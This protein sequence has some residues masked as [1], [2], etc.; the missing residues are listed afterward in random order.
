MQLLLAL[1]LNLLLN[2]LQMLAKY[3]CSGRQQMLQ[4]DLLAIFEELTR[5]EM[6]GKV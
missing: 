4:K 3:F 5:A 2:G 1:S 6:N